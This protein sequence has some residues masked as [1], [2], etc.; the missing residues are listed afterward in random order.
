MAPAPTEVE[1]GG[2]VR[3]YEPLIYPDPEHDSG[4]NCHV[5]HDLIHTWLLLVCIPEN[6]P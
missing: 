4:H 5:F 1:I 3:K 2:A 6:W